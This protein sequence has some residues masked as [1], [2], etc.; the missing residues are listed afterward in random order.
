VPLDLYL[1]GTDLHASKVRNAVDSCLGVGSEPCDIIT[2]AAGGVKINPGIEE[3]P[4]QS[5]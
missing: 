4:L 2:V 5:R 1:G 3:N